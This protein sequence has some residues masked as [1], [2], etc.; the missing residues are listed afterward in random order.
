MLSLCLGII[1]IIVPVLPTTPFVLLSAALFARSSDKFYCF[2]IGNRFFGRIIRDYRDGK[3]VPLK[4]K[5]WA[6]VILWLTISVSIVFA[7]DI[8]W[9]RIL[10]AVIAIAVT[11]HISTIKGR[12]K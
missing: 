5:S 2:L 11:I 4:V 9:V 10:L 12:K 6:I 7:V 8:L 1:G 3:G